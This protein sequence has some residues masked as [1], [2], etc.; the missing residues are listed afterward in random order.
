LKCRDSR[1]IC[2][3]EFAYNKFTDKCGN[4]QMQFVS[5]LFFVFYSYLKRNVQL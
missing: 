4:E 2:D 1:C 3:K 5:N